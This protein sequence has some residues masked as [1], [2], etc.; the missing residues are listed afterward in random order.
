MRGRWNKRITISG[1][2]V[3]VAVCAVLLSLLRPPAPPDEGQAIVLARAYLQ[4]RDEFEYPLGYWAR[5]VWDSKQGTWR[6]G[7]VPARKDG[8]GTIL[9]EVLRDRT[10]RT[11]S[12]DFSFFSLWY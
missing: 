12:M 2:L 10:C 1:L 5:A 4:S 11:P 9:V 3:L 6:V 8:G 7:F